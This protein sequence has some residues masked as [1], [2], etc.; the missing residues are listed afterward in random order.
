[1]LKKEKKLLTENSNCDIIINVPQE[2][3]TK[4]KSKKGH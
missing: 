1:M 4:E 2:S 3:G